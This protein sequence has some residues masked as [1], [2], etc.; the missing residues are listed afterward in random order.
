V[1]QWSRVDFAGGPQNDVIILSQFDSLK[2][3]TM[4][5]P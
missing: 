5:V 3:I 4:F 1:N 2:I